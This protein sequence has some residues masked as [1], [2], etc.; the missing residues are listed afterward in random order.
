MRRPRLVPLNR[1]KILRSILLRIDSGRAIVHACKKFCS[2]R[3]FGGEGSSILLL[4][5]KEKACRN[6]LCV[7]RVICLKSRHSRIERPD[8]SRKAS[9]LRWFFKASWRSL[10]R[11]FTLFASYRA[12]PL[13][14]KTKN[15]LDAMKKR[16]LG[17][18]TLKCHGQIV[19]IW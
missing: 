8:K 13:M 12:G 1:Y 4:Q 19:P 16:S 6:L 5:P 2:N 18:I 14:Q 7:K 3:T 15:R 9:A 11:L 10:P 17:Q